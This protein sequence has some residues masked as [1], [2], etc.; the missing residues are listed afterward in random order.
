[1]I[2][3]ISVSYIVW[4]DRYMTMNPRLL[5]EMGSRELFAQPGLNRDPP[6]L[7]L[8]STKELGALTT[9][10]PL[11]FYKERLESSSTYPKEREFDQ[12]PSTT[13]SKHKMLE[14]CRNN[15]TSSQ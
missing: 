4:D 9:W 2:L 8:P 15:W 5:V 11:S 3:P 7:S 14:I 6:D 10:F 1:M 12:W 13:V